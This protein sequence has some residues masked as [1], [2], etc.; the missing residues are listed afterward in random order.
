MPRVERPP[1]A[2]RV[3]ASDSTV[4]EVG[5]A[6]RMNLPSAI[7]RVLPNMSLVVT[8]RVFSPSASCTPYQ[9]ATCAR[10]RLFTTCSPN[11]VFATGL[12][13]TFK[14]GSTPARTT[15]W[16]RPSRL[17]CPRGHNQA[18]CSACSRVMVAAASLVSTM[19]AS[20][21]CSSTSRV[22]P[23]SAPLTRE[24]WSQA[25]LSESSPVWVYTPLPR[26][27][28]PSAWRMIGLVVCWRSGSKRAASSSIQSPFMDA[29]RCLSCSAS[30]SAWSPT[31]QDAAKSARWYSPERRSTKRLSGSAA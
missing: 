24:T 26:S 17:T 3:S 5:A 12:P 11:W 31:G 1:S 30:A 14:I 9:V 28:L 21:V 27:P 16:K 6:G 29:L 13:F 20:G 4:M 22:V 2:G 8:V 19:A 18:P 23:V 10:S 7:T 15:T 25:S